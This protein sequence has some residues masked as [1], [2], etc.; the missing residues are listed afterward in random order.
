MAN[1]NRVEKTQEMEPDQEN[2]NF[3]EARGSL[4]PEI[5][6][7]NARVGQSI[8]QSSTGAIPKITNRSARRARGFT[9]TNIETQQNGRTVPNISNQSL[10][11]DGID[12]PV[13][14][15]S[16]SANPQPDSNETFQI[17]SFLEDKNQSLD[18]ANELLRHY[19]EQVIRERE[20]FIRE[21]EKKNKGINRTAKPTARSSF[22]RE[23]RNYLRDYITL[24]LRGRRFS[25]EE[26]IDI[27]IRAYFHSIPA[28]EWRNAF[29][30]W[31]IRLQKC[32]D[33]G[34]D[35]FEHT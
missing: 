11:W 3:E 30:L 17:D 10:L 20:K 2:L 35:Y 27:A 19:D 26:E 1:N 32:I 7:S 16:K 22:E 15:V 18:E 5:T 34:G 6:F 23:I 9:R 4:N 21:I 29:H 13:P 28:E 31:K 8:T 12:L 14:D 33:A 25:S 24:H